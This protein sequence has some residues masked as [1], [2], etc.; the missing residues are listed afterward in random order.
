MRKT[1]DKKDITVTLMEDLASEANRHVDAFNERLNN[2]APTA[3]FQEKHTSG[4][5][6]WKKTYYAY[7]KYSEGSMLGLRRVSYETILSLEKS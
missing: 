7:Y 1:V 5:L 4:L 3:I 2:L 6:W